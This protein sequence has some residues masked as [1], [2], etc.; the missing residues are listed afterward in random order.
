MTQYEKPWTLLV[1]PKARKE[2][3]AIERT[4][5]EQIDAALLELG[6]NPWEGDVKSI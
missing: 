4:E 5:Q 3:E 1:H 6:Q 2:L